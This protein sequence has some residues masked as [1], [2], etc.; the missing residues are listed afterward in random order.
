MSSSLPSERGKVAGQRSSGAGADE[1]EATATEG[2]GPEGAGARGDPETAGPVVDPEGAGARGDGVGTGGGARPFPRP[3]EGEDGS[4]RCLFAGEEA[5]AP[6]GS[7]EEAAAPVL[8][9]ARF[10]ADD[11]VG[12]GSSSLHKGESAPGSD[13]TSSRGPVALHSFAPVQ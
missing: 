7:A 10:R 2:S 5:P 8:G 3:R 12:A 13:S 6:V 1:V 9:W 11:R 4:I